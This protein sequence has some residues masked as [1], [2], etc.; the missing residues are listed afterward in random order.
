MKT[1]PDI[2]V[3]KHKSDCTG[4]DFAG[5]EDFV[6]K[7]CPKTVQTEAIKVESQ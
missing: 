2:Q 4:Y 5:L 3:G 1:R 7:K 6:A